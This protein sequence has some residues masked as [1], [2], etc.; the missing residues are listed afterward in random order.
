ME[1]SLIFINSKNVSLIFK[2]LTSLGFILFF[3]VLFCFSCLGADT[4]AKMNPKE[5]KV[6][7]ITEVSGCLDVPYRCSCVC[8]ALRSYIFVSEEVR[9]QQ[10]FIA[11]LL[12]AE[13]AVSGTQ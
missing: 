10:A 9:T 8:T 13:G 2:G 1:L 5:E 7:I 12:S 3:F 11:H 6:K 4:A